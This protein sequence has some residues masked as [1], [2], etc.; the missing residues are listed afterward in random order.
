MDWRCFCLCYGL[1]PSVTEKSIIFVKKLSFPQTTPTNDAF[2]QPDWVGACGGRWAGPGLLLGWSAGID[3]AL[4]CK[5][6]KEKGPA[7][8]SPVAAPMPKSVSFREKR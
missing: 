7:G 2:F 8:V 4:L 3:V 6:K 1:I 5:N